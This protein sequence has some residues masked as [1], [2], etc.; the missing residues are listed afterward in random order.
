MT[1][2]KREDL[3]NMDYWMMAYLKS[4]DLEDLGWRSYSFFT[5]AL[6][7]ILISHRFYPSN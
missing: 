3:E 1:K 7:K 2:I 4:G 5:Y 6:K